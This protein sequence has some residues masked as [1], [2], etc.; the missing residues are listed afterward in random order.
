[1]VFQV[2]NFKIFKKKKKRKEKKKKTKER[3]KREKK[4]LIP[5]SVKLTVKNSSWEV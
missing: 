4:F 3:K 5:N 1:M 2:E